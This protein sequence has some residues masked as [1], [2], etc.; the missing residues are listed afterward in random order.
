MA[1]WIKAFIGGF[2]ATL[3][4]HQG[5][6]FLMAQAAPVPA[7]PFNMAPTE[8]LGIPAVFSLAFWG[9]VWGIP[10]WA[11]IRNLF[12]GRYWLRAAVLGALGP[13]AVF[14]FVVSPLKGGAFA[15][16]WDPKII[17]AGLILNAAWGI[18]L[19]LFMKFA[20]ARELHA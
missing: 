10:I 8:P 5:V 15:A 2:L 4:F 17:I 1:Q 11:L 18:G 16:G 14:L 3:I 6:Y 20:H 7:P 12:G 13:T 19:A 9:G